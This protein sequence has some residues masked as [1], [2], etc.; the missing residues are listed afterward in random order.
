MGGGRRCDL[1]RATFTHPHPKKNHHLLCK[2]FQ[3]LPGRLIRIHDA[4]RREE[5]REACSGATCLQGGGVVLILQVNVQRD[6][7]GEG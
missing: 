4:G 5:G 6:M 2:L 1:V 3:V 7:Q